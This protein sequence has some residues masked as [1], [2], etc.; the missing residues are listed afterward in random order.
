MSVQLTR[1]WPHV[2][3]THKMMIA[4]DVCVSLT[5]FF[6]PSTVLG[7]SS[8]Y[9]QSSTEASSCCHLVTSVSWI[10]TSSCYHY[11]V[12]VWVGH[13]TDTSSCYHHLVSWT[14]DRQIFMLSS[15]CKLDRMLTDTSCDLSLVSLTCTSSCYHDAIIICELDRRIILWIVW[16][17]TDTSSC[18][19]HLVSHVGKKIS[20][21]Y[22]HRIGQAHQM[23]L[24]VHDASLSPCPIQHKSRKCFSHM[25]C[26]S[27]STG[28][29]AP[30]TR[31][32]RTPL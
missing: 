7:A 29:H 18:Y 23:R 3:P 4:W 27:G 19:H 9:H 2:C 13:W 17:S 20:E 10:D 5:L 16:V 25:A 21:M 24:S 22:P 12:V 30:L 14:L 11:L 26:E 1:W 8:S 6:S 31:L 28:T 32:A 15:S